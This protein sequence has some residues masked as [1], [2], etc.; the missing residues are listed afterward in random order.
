[1]LSSL[2][3]RLTTQAYCTT[4]CGSLSTTNKLWRVPLDCHLLDKTVNQTFVTNHSWCH[5]MHAGAL[6]I[7]D[8]ITSAIG[9]PDISHRLFGSSLFLN[10]TIPLHSHTQH[11]AI[12]NGLVQT[13]TFV[14][15]AALSPCC[16]YRTADPKHKTKFRG[17]L[18]LRSLSKSSQFQ[19]QPVRHASSSWQCGS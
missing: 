2:E 18:H 8:I 1:M 9:R 3:T 5:G 14:Q 15:Q 7:A 13:A 12:Y 4:P 10:S 17:W 11:I 19:K 16:L 6:I